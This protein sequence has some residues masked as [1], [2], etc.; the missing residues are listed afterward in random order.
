MKKILLLSAV[1]LWGF[2]ACDIKDDL[3][4]CPGG[5]TRIQVYVEKFQHEEGRSI[6]ENSEAQFN[7][8]IARMHFYLYKGDELQEQGVLDM[9]N[10]SAQTYTFTYP[11]LS[12]GDYTLVLLGNTENN[13]PSRA[14]PDM[15]LV[16][17]G[18]AVTED[19]FRDSFEFTV[20]D[21]EGHAY[22][23]Q[24]KR[25]QGVVRFTFLNMPAYITGVDVSLD[26]LSSHSHRNGSY[27]DEY[28]FNRFQP[29]SALE[30]DENNAHSFSVLTFPTLE[31]ERTSWRVKLY[32]DGSEEPYFDQ[33]IL[34]DLQALRNQ[35]LDLVM[36]FGQLG[37]AGSFR[38]YVNLDGQWDGWHDVKVPVTGPN[39][40]N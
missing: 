23:T 9:T 12:Y 26:E 15:D 29:E 21:R 30:R 2:T 19:Y 11:A 33:V 25:V 40:W 6:P 18:Y 16:Y 10:V 24:L 31:N 38:Y 8:R 34:T 28:T 27:T 1:L 20:G 36:D 17:P 3:D 14:I 5:E 32:R 7:T 4:D 13:M 37:D 22:V 39:V 35:L